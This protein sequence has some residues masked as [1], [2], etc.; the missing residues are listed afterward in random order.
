MADTDPVLPTDDAPSADAPSAHRDHTV[1]ELRAEAKARGLHGYS[2]M[3]KAELL[4]A[5]D[6]A[7]AAETPAP[8]DAIPAPSQAPPAAEATPAIE[9]PAERPALSAA[10][11]APALEAAPAAAD[12][13]GDDESATTTATPSPHDDTVAQADAARDL[14]AQLRRT[15]P[16]QLPGDRVSPAMVAAGLGALLAVILLLR[17]RARRRR[18]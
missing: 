4:A 8:A 16:T 3:K 7:P 14:F 2:T 10:D 5:L 18:S 6:A 9:A 13:P 17:R 12:V 15:A 11:P 1:A